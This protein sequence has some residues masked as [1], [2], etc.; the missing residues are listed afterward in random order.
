MLHLT[1]LVKIVLLVVLMYSIY[2]IATM[3]TITEGFTGNIRQK[4]RPKVRKITSFYTKTNKN[5]RDK[6]KNIMLK[7]NR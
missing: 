3:P 6:F 1:K 7:K 5:I 2:I 4:I